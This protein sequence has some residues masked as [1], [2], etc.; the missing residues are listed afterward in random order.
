MIGLKLTWH[1]KKVLDEASKLL[2]LAPVLSFGVAILVLIL[3]VFALRDLWSVHQ[4]EQKQAKQ[5]QFKVQT[6][7]VTQKA[8][9]NYA[10]VLQR[11]NPLIKVTA[12]KE[13]LLVEASQPEL[14]AEFM[15]VLNSVQGLSNRVVWRAEEICLAGCNGAASR[16]VIKGTEEKV[17]VKLGVEND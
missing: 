1:S 4:A 12:D 10:F 13:S 11:L 15:M 7:G 9:E 5:P 16:A 14:F 17:T 2:G 8:Y 3:A 6:V